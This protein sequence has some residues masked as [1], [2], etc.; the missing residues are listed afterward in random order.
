VGAPPAAQKILAASAIAA[1]TFVNCLGV[2]SGT[3]TQN[4]FTLVKTAG[5]ALLGVAA[6]AS[7]RGDLRHFLSP[8]AA[9]SA[10]AAGSAGLAAAAGAAAHS[11]PVALALGLVTILYTYDGWIDVTY[12]AGEVVEPQRV[13]PRAIVAGTLVCTGLYLAANAA[14]LYLL[15]PAEIPRY[16]NVAAVA[17]GRAFGPAGGTALALLVVVS[18]LGILNGSILTG[19]RVPYAMGRDGTLFRFLGRVHP[20]SL[21]PVNALVAQGAFACLVVLFAKGFDEIASLFVST[22]WFFY[23]V[24]FIGL[25]VIQRRERRDLGVQGGYPASPARRA[26]AAFRMPLSP[27]PAV[28]FILVTLFIIGSDLVFSGPRVL[29]GMAIVLAGVPLHRVVAG[30]NRRRP[31]RAAPD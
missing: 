5:L 25:L 30:L 6:I 11:L 26:D 8:G 4:A 17:F 18:T 27:L 21:S 15:E 3:R 13:L 24:S 31:P 23:A 2:K 28:L 29:T 1:L 19:V 20:R 14:Y 10:A 12:T 7:G 22:T 9:G 16:E